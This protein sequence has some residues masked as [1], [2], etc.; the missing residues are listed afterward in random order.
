MRGRS[1]GRR[2]MRRRRGRGR[3]TRRGGGGRRCGMRRRGALRLSLW[4]LSRLSVGTE[5]TGRRGLRH[6]DR[7]RL[8]VRRCACEMHRRQSRGGKQ[9]ETK[10]CHD[11]VSPR[12]GSEQ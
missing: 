2:G 10:V 7:R 11:D 6:Y 9:R 8:R 3:G 5:F 12:K 4:R 1:G